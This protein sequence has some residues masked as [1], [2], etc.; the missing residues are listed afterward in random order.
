MAAV[1]NF[2]TSGMITHPGYPWSIQVP[3]VLA[4][5]S[6]Y[7]Q[8]ISPERWS[9]VPLWEKLIV[10]YFCNGYGGSTMVDLFLMRPPA[11]VSSPTIPS[12]YLAGCF[13]TF[14][15]PKDLIY[16][17]T[18]QR[19]HPLRTLMVFGDSVDG[20]STPLGIFESVV[21]RYPNN[22]AAPYVC[23][24]LANVGSGVF[25]FFERRGRGEQF[26]ME[27]SKPTG[28][29]QRSMGYI[30]IY[31]VLRRRFGVKFAR[32]VVVFC[33]SLIDVGCDL[34]GADSD[35]HDPIGRFVDWFIHSSERTAQ[36]LSLGPPPVKAITDVK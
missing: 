4:T 5:A 16:K 27:W 33:A 20:W 24:I 17:W 14:Y 32:L 23:A 21:E 34:I 22:W 2:L 10:A 6:G 8:S 30:L 18:Q 25:K 31:A 36:A 3:H 15:S 19:L 13:L 26:K 1:W 7:R 11:M 29:I 9:K 35:A 12:Y 28:G